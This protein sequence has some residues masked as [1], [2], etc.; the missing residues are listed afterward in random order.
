MDQCSDY[1]GKL[2]GYRRKLNVWRPPEM[3]NLISAIKSKQFIEAE[4][5]SFT[6]ILTKPFCC[7]FLTSSSMNCVY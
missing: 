5:K 1:I 2:E 3:N 6:Q 4:L 7:S